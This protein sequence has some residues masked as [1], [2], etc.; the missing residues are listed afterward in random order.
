MPF[1][2]LGIVLPPAPTHDNVIA[3]YAQAIAATPRLKLVLLTHMSHR[4]GLVLPVAEI[5]ALARARGADVIVDCAQSFYQIDF[6]LPDFGADFVGMNFH[7]WVG[8]PLGAAGIWIR[9][10]HEEIVAAWQKCANR[11]WLVDETV[12]ASVLAQKQA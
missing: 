4:H 10:G 5:V 9:K 7:K 12:I 11:C 3:A 1:A 6:K 8:A 2:A